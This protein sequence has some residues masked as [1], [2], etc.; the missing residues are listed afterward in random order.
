MP[1]LLPDLLHYLNSRD[2]LHDFQH[3]AI[4]TI[5]CRSSQY[6]GFTLLIL[7]NLTQQHKIQL[8]RFL[9]LLNCPEIDDDRLRGAPNCM[10]SRFT[11]TLH[12]WT[13]DYKWSKPTGPSTGHY[14]P[15][16]GAQLHQVTASRTPSSTCTTLCCTMNSVNYLLP[17]ATT[18]ELM[19]N[20]GFHH[21]CQPLFCTSVEKVLQRPCN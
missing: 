6:Y 2:Q 12:P 19:C 9:R 5:L 8:H 16:L 10:T 14:M 3:K 7:T 15:E 1:L 17:F 20:N 18:V 21:Y 4:T 13:V 11:T